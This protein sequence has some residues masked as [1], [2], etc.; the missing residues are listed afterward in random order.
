M[1][2]AT[3]IRRLIK[4]KKLIKVTW[5][6][7]NGIKGY[8]IQVATDKKF[9]KNIKTVTIKKAKSTKSKIK[10]LKAKKKYFVRICTYKVVN[11]RTIYSKWSPV[12]TIKTK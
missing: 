8:Q 3:K 6:K 10:K 7:I 1:P 11:G 2:N 5:N 9:K 12:K 4:G